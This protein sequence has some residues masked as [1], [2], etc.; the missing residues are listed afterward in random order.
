MALHGVDQPQLKNIFAMAYINLLEAI[1]ADDRASINSY[2]EGNMYRAFNEGLNELNYTAQSIKVMNPIEKWDVDI[3]D[4]KTFNEIF[5]IE[6]IDM[7]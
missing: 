6:I 4:D 2:C 5:D 1:A 3:Y 7:D